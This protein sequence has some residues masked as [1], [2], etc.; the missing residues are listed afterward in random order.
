MAVVLSAASALNWI[1]VIT[2]NG[3]DL[4]GL[5]ARAEAFAADPGRREGAPVFLPYLTGERTPH[6]DP[7]AVAAFDGLRIEHGPEA[8]AY[9]VLEGVGFALADCLDVLRQ[10][11]AAPRSCMLVGGG[12][13]SAYWNGLLAD[14]LQLPLD[15]PE[16]AEIG[17]AFGAARL[18]MIAAGA[19]SV[20]EICVKPSIR[21]RFEPRQE[22]A[23][24]FAARRER[25]LGLYRRK[26]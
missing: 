18:A 25:Y 26:P 9:A 6:N 2:G 24:L 14:I 16:G 20:T 15:L 19:G 23:S 13:R 1:S 11:D 22:H 4:Q 7:D 3:D 5:L 17:A 8:L 12:S 10:A 21:R